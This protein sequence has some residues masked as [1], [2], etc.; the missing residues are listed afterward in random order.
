MVA[1]LEEVASAEV[2][3]MDTPIADG[4]P[5]GV[6]PIPVLHAKSVSSLPSVTTIGRVRG[7]DICRYC[8]WHEQGIE[9]TGRHIS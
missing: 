7:Q 2:D 4:S 1:E 8:M 9:D 3:G 6:S 5:L